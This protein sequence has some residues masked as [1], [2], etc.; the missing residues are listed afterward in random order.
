MTLES[1]EE[2]LPPESSASG[3]NP[4]KLTI[5]KCGCLLDKKL[6]NIKYIHVLEVSF[7]QP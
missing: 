3:F 5:L 1:D 7:Y 4:S 6:H 2:D